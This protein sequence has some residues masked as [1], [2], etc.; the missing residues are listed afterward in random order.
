MTRVM[1][2]RAI[3]M[4][5]TFSFMNLDLHALVDDPRSTTKNHYDHY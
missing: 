4:D 1:T 5:E 2:C 3:I